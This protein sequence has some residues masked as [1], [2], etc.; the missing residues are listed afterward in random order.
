MKEQLESFDIGNR[1]CKAAMEQLLCSVRGLGEE[2]RGGRRGWGRGNNM[3]RDEMEQHSRVT[4]AWT[5]LRL[6]VSGWVSARQGD[7]EGHR[8]AAVLGD[9]TS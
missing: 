6:M 5:E 1:E 8:E 4:A 9:Q 2:K 7:G 3:E